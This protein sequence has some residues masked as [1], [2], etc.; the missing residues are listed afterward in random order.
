MKEFNEFSKEDQK[1]ICEAMW[2]N[3]DTALNALKGN[4][5]DHSTEF[6]S[7]IQNMSN[8]AKTHLITL[9]EKSLPEEYR[10]KL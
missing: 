5:V 9:L 2:M 7:C 10:R 3:N 8:D 6:K 4:V 1:L